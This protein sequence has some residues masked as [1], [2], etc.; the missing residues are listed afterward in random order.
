MVKIKSGTVAL[1]DRN[2]QELLNFTDIPATKRRIGGKLM[3]HLIGKIFYVNLAVTG[4]VA[5]LYNIQIT[6]TQ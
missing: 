1:P 5:Q 3:E 4:A 2:I 6:L